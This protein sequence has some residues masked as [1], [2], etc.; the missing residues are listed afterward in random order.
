MRND[1][2]AQYL[3]Y[4]LNILPSL[5]TCLQKRHPE[6]LR[7]LP[8]L[9]LRDHPLLT[10]HIALIPDDNFG[11]VL[12]LLLL[13][14]IH[15]VRN[16]GEGLPI[17]HTIHLELE[18]RYQNYARSPL[19]VRFGDRLEAL[20]PGSIPQLHFRRFSVDAHDFDLEVDADCGDVRRFVVG[21]RETQ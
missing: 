12:L 4:Q 2:P 13:D 20:L 1:L 8:S 3:K 17:A 10:R 14:L 15:P 19:I 6:F 9:S 11:C 5:G 21:V 16:I 18:H 7:H